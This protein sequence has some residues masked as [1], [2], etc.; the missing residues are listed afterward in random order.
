MASPKKYRA[1]IARVHARI[2]W[3]YV[4]AAKSQNRTHDDWLGAANRELF[5]HAEAKIQPGGGI[6]TEK[7]ETPNEMID[8]VL[9]FEAVAGIK[10]AM[11]QFISSPTISFRERQDAFIAIEGFGE[12]FTKIVRKAAKL[13]DSGDLDEDAELEGMP[14]V[15][16]TKFTPVLVEPTKIP[17]EGRIDHDE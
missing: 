2:L 9:S 12:E 15:E 1:R 16:E 7:M 4:Q 11:V 6:H 8:I 5:D 13:P 17:A 3:L 14:V 10:F